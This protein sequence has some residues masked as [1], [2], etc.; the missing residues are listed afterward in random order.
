MLFKK[1]PA[2]S[3]AALT[4]LLFAPGVWAADTLTD[5]LTGG[6]ASANLQ[7]RYEGVSQVGKLAANASTVRLQLGYET[8][9]FNGLGA[10]IEIESTKALGNNYNSTANGKTAYAIVAD[11]EATE[12]NQAYLSYSGIA[13]TTVKWGRQRIKLD[14]E[15]YF[16]NVFWRQ[17]EQTFD[18]FTLV[19]KSLPD[20]TITAGYITNVN[21]VFSDNALATTG[22]AAG[23]HKMR[24]TLLNANYKGW[25]LAEL[26][27]YAYLLDYDTAT[28]FTA[29]S[30]DTYGF[31]MKGSAP[32]GDNKL[33]YAA[34][35]A[36]QSNGHGNTIN[37]KTN[38]TLL[39]GG[40]DINSAVFKLGY[41]VLGTDTG[42]TGAATIKSFSTPLALLHGF[43]GW[44]DMFLATPAQGLKDAYVSANT[45]LAGLNLGAVYHDYR[46]DKTTATLS[47]SSIGNEWG[48]VATKAFDKNYLIGFK[49]A[50]YQAK[51]TTA[52]TFATNVNTKKTWLWG[53]FKF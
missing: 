47:S 53:A 13:D 33:L 28:A 46:A 27:G 35:F 32:M 10:M 7:Y 34:E 39:E 41:E 17:N 23:N 51:G 8:A 12:I 15:R 18:A 9:T 49:Y 11:P 38:Y 26:S 6:K 31:R 21:R 24:S 30:T 5:A 22:A 2:S 37:F 40:I 16:S 50:D 43:N 48:F 42:A 1:H 44:A 45:K 29:F 25:S 3:I 36:S 14:N 4:A 52:T 19:N 20:T